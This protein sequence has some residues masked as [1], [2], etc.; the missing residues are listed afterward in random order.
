MKIKSQRDFCSGGIFLVTGILF[1]LGAT[2]YSMG[3]S[4]NPGAGYFP[5]LLGVILALLGAL[6]LFRSLGTAVDD[7]ER[8]GPIAWRPL[9]V[10]VV[11]IA[12][13]G[14]LLPRMGLLVTVPVLVL[15]VSA[16]GTE[17]SWKGG[18]LSAAVL[19]AFAWLV[20]V[21][22]LNLIIPLWPAFLA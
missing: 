21:Y 1:A 12:T 20:F 7:G 5:L 19:T 4:A 6:V 9:I 15:M 13:F 16:A 22:G 14:F 2:E 17:F 10:I 11:S 18:L 8:V 3:T